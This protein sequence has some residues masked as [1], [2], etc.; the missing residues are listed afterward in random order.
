[1]FSCW[2]VFRL[3][4]EVGLLSTVMIARYYPDELDRLEGHFS[5]I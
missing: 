4:E 2:E 5:K 1:M 3:G